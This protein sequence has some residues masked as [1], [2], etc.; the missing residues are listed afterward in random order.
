MNACIANQ[1]Q[2]HL[3][4]SQRRTRFKTAFVE[5]FLALN[6]LLDLRENSVFYDSEGK[7][8]KRSSY[9]TSS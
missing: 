3:D 5:D 6:Y 4:P 9:K 8:C 1:K 2:K 7:S